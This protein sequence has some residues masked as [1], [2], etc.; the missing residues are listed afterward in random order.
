MHLEYRQCSIADL[1]QLTQI[2]KS[3][4]V[5]AFKADNDP[6]DFKSY[7]DFAFNEAKLTEELENPDSSFYFTF[8][9]NELVGYF[10]LNKG[11]AQSELKSEDSLEL[12]RIYVTSEFQ[13]KG[14]GKRMLQFVKQLGSKTTKAFL[15]LGVWERNKAAINFY[16]REGFSKFGVHPYYIGK[17]KQTDWLMRFDFLNFSKD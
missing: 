12:E 7:L 3:T 11:K 2:S 9:D 8:H 4:F 5:E 13:G 10:K 1:N 6:E 14:V 16:E 17:D 15:W